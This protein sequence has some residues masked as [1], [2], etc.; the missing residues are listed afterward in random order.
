MKNN[1]DL[2]QNVAIAYAER[3]VFE[4][5]AQDILKGAKDSIK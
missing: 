4:K 3:I 1:N 2:V 5:A